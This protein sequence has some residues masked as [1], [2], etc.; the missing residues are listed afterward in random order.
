MVI[1][2][3]GPGNEEVG[4]AAEFFTFSLIC[5]GYSGHIYW[6]TASMSER[7]KKE[8]SLVWDI[9]SFSTQW[10]S[11]WICSECSCTCRSE[12]QASAQDW[13]YISQLLH[14]SIIHLHTI[15]QFKMCNSMALSIFPVMQ[16]PSLS[17]LK[18]I[19]TQEEICIP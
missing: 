6:N 1:D 11:R 7:I 17:I 9:L 5:W 4:M 14:C 15:H 3:K 10:I 12:A 19:I 18:H 16:S 8:K 13:S 2:V